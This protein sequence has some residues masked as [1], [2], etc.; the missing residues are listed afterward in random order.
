MTDPRRKF[1]TVTATG[2]QIREG[3]LVGC[4]ES[5]DPEYLKNYYTLRGKRE[6]R[7]RRYRETNGT[8]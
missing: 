2:C 8:G 1:I 5:G 7:M 3:G 6:V 4:P